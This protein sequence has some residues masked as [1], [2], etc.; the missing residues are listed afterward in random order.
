[1]KDKKKVR[2]SQVIPVYCSCRMPG[3]FGD[4]MILNATDAMSGF[5]MCSCQTYNGC[6][7]SWFLQILL[8]FTLA[9]FVFV[10]SFV[11]LLLSV[12]H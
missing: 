12:K 11:C 5:F 8:K 1:M 6:K 3:T 2:M 9:V 10:L 4:R 7:G